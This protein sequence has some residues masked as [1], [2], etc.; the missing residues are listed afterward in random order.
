MHASE[1]TV[2]QAQV[3]GRVFEA[4]LLSS[5]YLPWATEVHRSDPHIHGTALRA[6]LQRPESEGCFSAASSFLRLQGSVLRAW[7]IHSTGERCSR[8]PLDTFDDW[9]FLFFSCTV[10]KTADGCQLALLE[11]NSFLSLVAEDSL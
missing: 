9:L 4:S 5:A 2:L 1:E 10:S 6:L 7:I 11:V 3:D 8:M